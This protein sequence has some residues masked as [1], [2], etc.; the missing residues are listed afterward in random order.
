M[1]YDKDSKSSGDGRIESEPSWDIFDDFIS[2]NIASLKF[3]STSETL[4]LTFHRGNTYQYLDVPTE[5]WN[6]FK[7]ADSQAKYLN[8]YIKGRFRYHRIHDVCVYK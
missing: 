6:G 1:C 5:I 4:E 2:S 3:D 7:N 8:S